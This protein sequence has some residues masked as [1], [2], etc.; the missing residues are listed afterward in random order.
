M[1][2]FILDKDPV[3]AAQMQCDKHVVKMILESAQMLST[4]MD[5]IGL[6]PPYRPTHKNHP[7]N[8]WARKSLE[9]YQW[10]WRHA[11]ALGDEYTRRYGKIHKTHGILK[12]NIPYVV[13][14]PSEG[15]TPFINATPYKDMSD[16][17][18][19]YHTY[20]KID[21]ISFAKWKMGNTPIW[22]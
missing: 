8:V 13:S 11:D 1:N 20:Y 16:I 12:E 4:A 3:V 5:S 15:L 7:C 14:L 21:K 17:V 10:L 2:I 22:F 19:A 9:N 18:E 6:E